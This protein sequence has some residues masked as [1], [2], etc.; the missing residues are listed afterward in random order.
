MK[1]N[2]FLKIAF[3]VLLYSAILGSFPTNALSTEYVVMSP[4]H[5]VHRG[6]GTVPLRQELALDTSYDGQTLNRVFVVARSLRGQAE[7]SLFGNGANLFRVSVANEYSMVEIPVHRVLGSDLRSVQLITRGGVEIAV[8]GVSLFGAADNRQ[9]SPRP[10][11]GYPP[12]WSEADLQALINSLKADSFDSRRTERLEEAIRFDPNRLFDLQQLHRILSLFD[13]DSG[14]LKA[15]SI[16]ARNVLVEYR[17]ID[18]GLQS[19]DFDSNRLKAREILIRD[20]QR[21]Y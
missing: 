15:V 10:P 21:P 20:R 12:V 9:P 17:L 7:V 13:F 8:V 4:I 16:L 6:Q 2:I 19:F 11:V 5:V 1:P 3:Q 18:E 14:R